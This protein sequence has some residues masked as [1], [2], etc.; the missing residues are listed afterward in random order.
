MPP[1]WLK[2]GVADRSNGPEMKSHRIKWI[3]FVISGMIV[4]LAVVYVILLIHAQPALHH[5]FTAANS[6]LVIAHRGGISLGPENTLYTFQRAVEMGVDVLEMDVR[7]TR[8]HQLVVIHDATVDRTTDGTGPVS[9]YGLAEIQSLDAGYHWSPDNGA[10]Y[11]TRASGIQ[12]P[13]LDE[14]L[15]AFPRMRMNV[16]IKDTDPAAIASLCNV[17]NTQAMPSRIMVACFDARVLDKF[18]RACPQVATSAGASEVTTFYFLQQVNLHA[19]YS[20]AALALQV[21]QEYGNVKI[22]S[23]KFIDAAHQRN[24]QVHVWTVNDSETMRVLMDLGVD[25]IMTDYPQRLM[26][27]KK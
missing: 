22:L 19:I 25:G 6:F 12:I 2:T 16:E 23:R 11:P 8:D 10:S 3:A 21:P 20:P 13:V 17:I 7:L 5:P 1:V 18:R 4:G 9:T 15:A 26:A 14:V 27:L 24:L